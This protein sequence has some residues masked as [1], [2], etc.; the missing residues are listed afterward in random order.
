[1]PELSLAD[2]SAIEDLLAKYVLGLDADDLEAVVDLFV[3][4]GAFN[5][6][7]RTF[8][9]PDSFRRML[10]S[11]PKGM[12]LAG[13]SLIRP[14]ADG[15]TIRQQLVFLPADGSATRLAIYD[16]EVVRVEGEWRFRT[17]TCRFMAS[18]GGLVDKP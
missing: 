12:H 9:V 11:A 7:G 17:R 4:G 15:A 5:T 2:R 14:H 1:M 18:D 6:Y 8:V 3:P 16:D 10:H 13:R